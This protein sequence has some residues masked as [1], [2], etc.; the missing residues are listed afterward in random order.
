[1][2]HCGSLVKSRNESGTRWAIC[3]LF[4]TAFISSKGKEGESAETND[5]SWVLL[6]DG[7][8]VE[9]LRG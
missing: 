9:R 7:S 4:N 6:D 1:M 5:V 2:S 3:A 8:K